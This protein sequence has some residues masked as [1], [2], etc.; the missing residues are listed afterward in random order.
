MN[1]PIKN[2]PFSVNIADTFFSR[3]KGLMFRS[4]PL[5]EEGLLI[6]PCNSIHMCF[7][8]F[9]IDA[10]FLNK[11]GEI[12]NMVEGIKP[13]RFIKPVRSASSVL[14]LP[15]GSI[16]ELKLNLGDSLALS[17]FSITTRSK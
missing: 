7:M 4:K 8:S 15:A 10:V 6:T 9:P 13:W 3:L 17:G 14:E 16:R 1:S 5:I 12:I 11:Q 2:I